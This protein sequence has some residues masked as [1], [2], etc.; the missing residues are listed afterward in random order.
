MYLN[1]LDMLNP[2]ILKNYLIIT[3]K[4]FVPD[5]PCIHLAVKNVLNA[6]TAADYYWDKPNIVKIKILSWEKRAKAG[7]NFQE[8]DP[9]TKTST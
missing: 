4:Q 9:R 2:K 7:P 1:Y 6:V 8:I 5:Y 3:A